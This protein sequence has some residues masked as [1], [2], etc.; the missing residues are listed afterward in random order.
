MSAD[1]MNTQLIPTGTGRTALSWASVIESYAAV[2]QPFK[3]ACRPLL[4]NIQP[5]PYAVFAPVIPGFK[6]KAAQQLICELDATFY[7]WER[8]NNQITSIAYPVQTI[9]VIEVGHILLYSWIAI[10]GMTNAGLPASSTI[11]FNTVS[12]PHFEPFVRQVRPSLQANDEVEWQAEKT[13]FNYL[14]AASYKF[15]NYAHESL[16][17]G[18][19]VIQTIWQPQIHKPVLTL[20][21]RSLY[22]TLSLAHLAILTDQEVIFVGDDTRLTQVRGER[23]GGIWQYVPLRRIAAVSVH[24]DQHNLLTLSLTLSPG[25][26]RLDKRFAASQEQPVTRF[27]SELEQLIGTAS[28]A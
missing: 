14:E 13:K 9:N 28:P 22:R 11:P 5:F 1:S 19:R 18:A 27:Q 25:A 26:Q 24:T 20:F 12:I 8:V 23:H 4:A 17:P 10:T 7:I 16:Q 15:W 2:P 21:G 3:S 6:R